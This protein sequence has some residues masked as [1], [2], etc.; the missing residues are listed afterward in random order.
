MNLYRENVSKILKQINR[1]VIGKEEIISKVFIAMLA[2][3]H[4]LLEDVP[5]VGKTTLAV[6][7]SKTLEL[8]QNRIQFTPD[9]LP[10]DVVGYTMISKEDYSEIYKPGAIMCNLLL[11]DEINRTSS[12][13]QSALLEV[14]EEGKVTVDKVTRSVPNPFIV[15][16]T[17]NPKGAVGTQLLPDSQLDRFMV[18]LHMGYPD[19]RSEVDMLKRRSNRNPLNE[20]SM[21]ISKNQL[22]NMQQ[23]VEEVY[24]HDALYDYIVWL[25]QRT[26][27]NPYIDQ[28][29]SPRGTLALMNMSKAVAY[30]YNRDY[31]IPDDIKYIFKDVINHRIIMSGQAK[32]KGVT[33]ESV[34]D[35]ILRKTSTPKIVVAR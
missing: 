17:Q 33:K 14:M 7:F 24:L 3:G 8:E 4:I 28:G 21:V 13:T 12:K 30:C 34:V 6:A 32:L 15:I 2:K 27:D 16:A 20:I 5:G 1:V 25:I 10:S 23:E 19:Q 11:A 31:V 9:V 26:R 22:L 35:D 18:R 29:V